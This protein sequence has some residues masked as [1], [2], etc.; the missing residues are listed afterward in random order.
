M[1]PNQKTTPH[2]ILIVLLSALAVFTIGLLLITLGL[3][4]LVPRPAITPTVD[5][6]QL[7]ITPLP[8]ITQPAATPAPTNTPA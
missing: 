2:P 8:Q 3:R 7:P 1:T 6:A 4:S 5:M